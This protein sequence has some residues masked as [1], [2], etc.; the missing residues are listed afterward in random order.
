MCAGEMWPKGCD[1]E[2]SSSST[3]EGVLQDEVFRGAYAAVVL[4][5]PSQRRA[6][7]SVGHA[8]GSVLLSSVGCIDSDCLAGTSSIGERKTIASASAFTAVGTSGS[9]TTAFTYY[10]VQY[11][12]NEL[13]TFH[14]SMV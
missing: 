8:D 14:Q 1:C 7:R 11:F 4:S 12:K 9:S 10:V 5:F 13:V 3:K 6:L 2:E